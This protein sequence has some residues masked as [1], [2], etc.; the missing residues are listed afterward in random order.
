MDTAIVRISHPLFTSPAAAGK[1]LIFSNS[2]ENFTGNSSAEALYEINLLG[3]KAAQDMNISVKV[4]PQVGV[5]SGTV[6]V[7]EI[8]AAN[9]SVPNQVSQNID[10]GSVYIQGNLGAI[11]VGDNFSTPALKSL[12]VMSISPQQVDA[13]GDAAFESNVLG[14]IVK[15]NV[16]GNMSGAMSIIGYQFGSIG[17]LTIGGS[18]TADSNNDQ[19]S[20]AIQFTGHI[21]AATIGSIVGG[22]GA[23]TGE[24]LGVSSQPTYINKLD[25]LGSVEGGSGSFSGSVSA[26]SKIGKVI[27]G[28]NLEGGSGSN[29]G[30][31]AAPLGNVSIGGFVEGGSGNSSGSIFSQTALTSS[32]FIPLPMGNVTIGGSVVGGSAGTGTDATGTAGNSGVI[33]GLSAKNIS[34]GGS[35]MGG[36]P[37]MIGGTANTSGAVLVDSVKSLMI[38]QNI[39]GGG[40][41]ESGF[42]QGSAYG[43]IVVNGS[44][45]G[46]SAGSSGSVLLSLGSL[47]S[48]RV[49]GDLTGG[50]ATGAGE[51]EALFGLNS[52]FVGGNVN[53]GTASDTG[54][55]ITSANLN[56]GIINGNLAGSQTIASASPVTNTAIIEAGN[57]VKLTIG[58]DVIAGINTTPIPSSDKSDLVNIT[59][60]GAIRAAGFIG[61]LTIDGTVTGYAGDTINKLSADPVIIS[62]ATGAKNSKMPA[63][64]IAINSLTIGGAAEYLDVLA[65]YNSSVSTTTVGG[66]L[67]SPMT[68]SA[69]INSVLFKS[70]IAATNIVAGA[71]SD[72]ATGEFGT[73]TN[74]LISAGTTPSIANVTIEGAIVDMMGDPNT[75]GIVANVLQVVSV[76]G[77]QIPT[78]GLTFNTPAPING[79]N[80]NL[81]EVGS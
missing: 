69:Q 17:K 55:I 66:Q 64:N 28:G 15:M 52:F 77:T 48:L 3:V 49:G 35:L 58:G 5:G 74:T 18:L 21:G 62:A 39:V 27:I 9:F 8:A 60:S 56:S 73:S 67:G 24:I 61:S 46:G 59:N 2:S 47:G 50:S 54:A 32:K 68:G 37:D 31:V 13:T 71:V 70:S 57:I 76:D 81:L 7:G 65:G 40:G 4:I 42:V 14:P 26:Q 6:S 43:S 22:T 33:S 75:Y 51:V 45:T 29:S 78:D 30:S 79:T 38:G 11:A 41:F 25:V 34:I 36:S 80:T 23:F 1:I 44:I 53:G 72:P 19:G 10:L 20:G 63:A 12:T 16:M